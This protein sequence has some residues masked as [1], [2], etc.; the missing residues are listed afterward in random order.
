MMLGKI[1]STGAL[2]AELGALRAAQ[3][4]GV[5]TGGHCNNN[6]LMQR[7][8]LHHV[9]V[10]EP[11]ILRAPR[12]DSPDYV[13]A[14]EREQQP[15]RVTQAACVL[16]CVDDSDGVL[17]VAQGFNN[18]AERAVRLYCERQHKPS[19]PVNCGLLVDWGAVTRWFDAHPIVNLCVTGQTGE[20]I[21]LWTEG[22]VSELLTKIPYTR[23]IVDTQP[24]I[25]VAPATVVRKVLKCVVSTGQD[26]AELGGLRAVSEHNLLAGKEREPDDSQLVCGRRRVHLRADGVAPWDRAARVVETYGLRHRMDRR[27]HECIEHVIKGSDAVLRIGVGFNWPAE[28]QIR[29]LCKKYGK[30]NLCISVKHPMEQG[31]V[32]VWLRENNVETLC[33][34][35]NASKRMQHIEKWV[36]DY[37]VDVFGRLGDDVIAH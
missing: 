34:T 11:D 31:D 10:G 17:R 30:P 8:G 28:Q 9:R 5:L 21:A 27:Y 3:K 29:A 13:P 12:S 32:V 4:A 19:L 6:E 26:G 23:T 25:I 18:R 14:R 16:R 2:G 35:G 22:F 20:G 1:L 24:E 15:L 37:L 36:S 33:V 7:F